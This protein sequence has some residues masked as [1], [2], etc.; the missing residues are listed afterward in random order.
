MIRRTRKHR[1]RGFTIIEILVVVGLI[2]FLM[3]ISVV[4]LRNSISLARQRQTEATIL[5]L[6]GLMQQRFDAFYRAMERTNLQQAKDKMRRDWYTTYNMIPPDAAIEVMVKKSIVQSRFP[7]NFLEKNI[8]SSATLP[9]PAPHNINT[10]SAAL[11]YWILTKSEVFGIAPVDESEFSSVEVRDTDGD[12]LLEFVDGWGQPLRYYRWPCHLFRPGDGAAVPPGISAAG[13]LS[14]PDRTFVSLIWQGLPAVPTAAGEF[15]PLARDPDDPTGQL[16]LFINSPG[17]PAGAATAVQ[18]FYGTPS[19]Y[20]AFL[21][22]SAGRD[23]ILG[24]LEPANEA[25]INITTPAAGLPQGRLAALTSWTPGNN[26][27]NDNVTNRKR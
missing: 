4:L 20:N 7:Q 15:D 6:H 23:G 14:P 27:I 8:S 21:I 2:L 24:L 25:T 26:P 5:K 22:M 16:W 11:L 13:A 10:Q 12:G 3:S 19:T 9:P 18:N 1:R 17:A